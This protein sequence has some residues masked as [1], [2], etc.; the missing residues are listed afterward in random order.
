MMMKKMNVSTPILR[1]YVSAILIFAGVFTQSVSAQGMHQ[2]A[3]TV[4]L[5]GGGSAYQDLYHANFINPANLMLNMETRPT[6]TLSLAGGIHARAGG[7]LANIAVY[8]DYLTGGLTI[9]SVLADE[10]LSQW[11]GDSSSGVRDFAFDAGVVPFGGVYRGEGWAMGFASRI[12]TAGKATATRGLADLIFRGLDSDY[13]NE[14]RTVN[15]SGEYYAWHEWSAGYARTIYTQDAFL[16]VTNNL[17]IYAGIAPKL[18]ISTDY[19]STAMQSTLQINGFTAESSGEINHDFRYAIKTAG[20]RS[21]QLEEFR[22]QHDLGNDPKLDDYLEP[23]TGDFTGTKGVSIGLDLGL[24]AE[25]DLAD[26][27]FFD[28]GIFRGN[29]SL[30]I[31]LSLTDIGSLSFKDRARTFS[32]DDRLI[33]TGFNYDRELI[34]E[35]FGGDESAYFESV[36]TDSIGNDIYANFGSESLDKHKTGLPAMGRIGSHLILGKFG[37]MMDIGLGLSSRGIGSRNLHLS[38]GSEYR[39]FNRIPLRAGIRMGGYSGT[40]L[41][42]GTGVELRNFEFTFGAATTPRSRN[43]GAAGAA[44]WSGFVVHF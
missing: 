23:T 16:G 15:L 34:D 19:T 41:H 42:A 6:F 9:N 44:A 3:Q 43:G 28:L 1:A 31:G 30:R 21:D 18:L 11:F 40:T 17:R 22:I 39:F 26:N 27:A 10:M 7:S 38:A 35:E 25:M 2:T 5:G 37:F 20:A 4:S 32:A 36:I 33:W 8:N 12:R 29:K 13:F 24:T 14:A